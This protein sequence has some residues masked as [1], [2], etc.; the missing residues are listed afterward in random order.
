M[1]SAKAVLLKVGVHT[2]NGEQLATAVNWVTKG[3]VICVFVLHATF[4]RRQPG[5]YFCS[6]CL[7]YRPDACVI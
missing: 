7:A 5:A 1:A 6:E 4:F 2:Y 3:A